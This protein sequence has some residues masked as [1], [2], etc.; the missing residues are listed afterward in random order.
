VRRADRVWQN[1]VYAICSP[2]LFFSADFK[3]K[4]ETNRANQ[5]WIFDLI[6]K[7][8]DPKKETVYMDK[9]DWMLVRGSSHSKDTKRYL[10][11]FK[12]TTLYT[13]R[14]LRQKHLKMLRQMRNVVRSFLAREEPN[15]GQFRLYFHYLPSVFQ[16]HLH[17][18]CTP[19]V[20]CARRQY[21]PG[22]IRNIESND[23]WYR[24][25]LM[26]FSC[27]RTPR[28]KEAAAKEAFP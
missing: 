26:L 7:D 6:N 19:P 15:N 23:T 18:C 25:A 22:V 1:R 10:V 11:V 27:G 16:L 14:D 28:A 17:V 3:E 2:S 24:D 12:D 8:F 13:I 21:L 9:K 5:K 20:D 4:M